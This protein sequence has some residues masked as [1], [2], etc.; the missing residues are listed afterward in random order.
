MKTF[1]RLLLL[2]LLFAAASVFGQTG[3]LTVRTTVFDQSTGMAVPNHLVMLTVYPDSMNVLY[4]INDTALTDAAGFCEMSIDVPYSGQGFVNFSV[5]TPECNNNLQ[6]QYFTYSGQSEVINVTFSICNGIPSGCENYILIEGIDQTTVSLLGGLYNQQ[7]AEFT[8]DFGDGAVGSGAQVTHSYNAL[9]MYLVTLQTVTNDSCFDSSSITVYLQDSVNF[10]CINFIEFVPLQDPLEIQFFGNVTSQY[11]SSFEWN[12]GDPVSG[13]NNTSTLQNPVHLFTSPGTYT[14]SLSTVDSTGCQFTSVMPVLVGGGGMPSFIHGS[15]IAGNSMLDF[16]TVTLFVL[17]SMGYYLP[18]QTTTL[19]SM[20]Y[21]FPEVLPGTYLIQAQPSPNSMFFGTYL[22]TFYQSSLFWEDATQI[23]LGQ[24]FNPYDI[25]LIA[26]DSI[27]GGPGII[28]GQ[29]IG[30]G[31]SVA[32]AGIEV[33]LLNENNEPVRLAYTDASGNF[34][35]GDLPLGT[36]KLNPVLTGYTIDI[37]PCTLNEENQTAEMVLEINGHEITAIRKIDKAILT[38][39]AYPNPVTSVLNIKLAN[40][41]S[42]NLSVN[43]YNNNGVLVSGNNFNVH[44]GE[45]IKL[46]TSD[47]ATGLYSVVLIDSKGNSNVLQFIKQ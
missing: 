21:F 24:P 47:L 18:V 37:Y 3:N 29:I 6:T 9:G 30:G 12:F 7:D 10:D 28:E 11:P 20:M 25:T 16:G 32:I 42:G 40:T 1:T 45:I 19:D 27:Q 43:I 26:Y 34:S 44:T 8:W 33:L 13:I 31:K 46:N 17:D 5:S 23:I 41:I 15:V 39:S 22:P 38:E 14:I 2:I 4:P 36:Y 35:F